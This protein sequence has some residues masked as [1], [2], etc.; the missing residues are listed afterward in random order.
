MIEASLTV[1]AKRVLDELCN[2][3]R[4]PVPSERDR[5]IVRDKAKVLWNLASEI[6][7][8]ADE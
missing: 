1:Q 7:R 2:A 5:Q 3:N 4:R 8:Q 6:M